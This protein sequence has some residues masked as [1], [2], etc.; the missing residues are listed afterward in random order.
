MRPRPLSPCAPAPRHHTAARGFT[1]IEAA[2]VMVVISV[3]IIAMLELLAS[4]TAANGDAA[5][6]TTGMALA[7]SVRE[8][9]TGLAFYD[10][11]QNPAVPPGRVWNSKEATTA[12]YDNVMDLDGPVDTWDKPED[13]TGWQK[14]SPPRD[15]TGRSITVPGK[16]AQYV[17]VENVDP[18][19]F[20]RNLPHDPNCEVVRVTAKITRDD[21]EVYRS[22]WMV[23]APL[24]AKKNDAP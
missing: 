9:S 13:A 2:M 17:K 10:P 21:V 4:G 7:A 15:G 18:A 11:D 19:S 20:F 22:S 16:W 1:L 14:F 24:A 5:K 8:W 3:G 12:L 6:S 23:F